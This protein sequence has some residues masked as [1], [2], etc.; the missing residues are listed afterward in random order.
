MIK[1][2]I[3]KF[4]NKFKYVRELHIK[5]GKYERMKRQAHEVIT[6]CG[7]EFPEVSCTA[8][9]ILNMHDH[10][11]TSGA[12]GSIDCFRRTLRDGQCNWEYAAL[13]PMIGI[14]RSKQ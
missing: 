4:L 9:W 7:Y 11:P 6:W 1:W 5:I 3:I 2:L 12:W 8:K 13:K 10:P 14:E